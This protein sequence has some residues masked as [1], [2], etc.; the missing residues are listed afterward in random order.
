M[1]EI[2]ERRLKEGKDSGEFGREREMGFV[3]DLIANGS[4]GC[5]M[6]TGEVLV[7]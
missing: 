1:R 5:G 2:N 3:I 6:C 4:G 7:L